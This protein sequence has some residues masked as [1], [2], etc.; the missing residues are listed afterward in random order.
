MNESLTQRLYRE[1]PNL[2]CDRNQPGTVTRMCDGF[3]CDDG[4]FDVIYKLSQ[5]LERMIVDYK[6][7]NKDD[8]KPPRASQVKS[9]FGAL[10][11]YMSHYTSDEMRDAIDE[12]Q[13]K[14]HRTCEKCG[15][16]GKLRTDK[17]WHATLCEEHNKR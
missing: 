12:A 9:K 14:S 6:R 8:P 7:N 10:C 13:A 11:F 15:R 2:Y 3:A 16:P 1:F 17:R 5:R 4:W